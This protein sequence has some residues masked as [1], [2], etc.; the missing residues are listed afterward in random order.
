MINL[1]QLVYQSGR[2]FSVTQMNIFIYLICLVEGSGGPHVYISRNYV[3]IERITKFLEKSSGFAALPCAHF[4]NMF[5]LIEKRYYFSTD[6]S[7]L[8]FIRNIFLLRG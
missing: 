4:K 6:K 3:S 2:C 1:I 5:Y 8:S 7:F